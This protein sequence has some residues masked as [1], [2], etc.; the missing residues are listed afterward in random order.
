MKMGVLVDTLE[1]ATTWSNLLGL[2]SQIMTAF[3]E[4]FEELHVSGFAMA[5]VSHVY[6]T[7][8]SLYFTFMAQQLMGREEEEWRLIKNRAAR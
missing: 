7:G 5:H 8:A 1:T 6:R 2:H 4:S 3:H